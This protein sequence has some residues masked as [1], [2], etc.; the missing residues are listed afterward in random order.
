[1]R[2]RRASLRRRGLDFGPVER[3]QHL[4]LRVDAFTQ[5]IA[6]LARQKGFGQREIQVVLFEAA[7]SAHFNHVAK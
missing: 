2:L 5:G 6:A 7:F 4:T 3:D 1:M